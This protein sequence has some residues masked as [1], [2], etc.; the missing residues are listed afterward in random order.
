[1]F[2]F[3]GGGW[4]LLMNNIWYQMSNNQKP[5]LICC[6]L[7]HEILPGDIGI[8]TSHYEDPSHTPTS[9]LTECQPRVCWPVVQCFTIGRFGT[10][11]AEVRYPHHQSGNPENQWSRSRCSQGFCDHS[12]PK[13]VL[14]PILNESKWGICMWIFEILLVPFSDIS[15]FC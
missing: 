13:G 9:F 8:I 2:L 10:I 7:G 6:I 14:C 11:Q 5:L 12:I 4:W 3:G 15:W 1:M